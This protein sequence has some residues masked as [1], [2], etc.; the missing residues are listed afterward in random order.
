MTTRVRNALPA[1]A[2]PQNCPSR[3]AGA[4][5]R[6]F[7]ESGILVGRSHDSADAP[8]ARRG[9]IHSELQPRCAVFPCQQSNLIGG[10]MTP[11]Y[12]REHL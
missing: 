3:F 2:S 5:L 7:A 4:G 6:F 12:E 8:F 1:G 11:P 10:V 9:V